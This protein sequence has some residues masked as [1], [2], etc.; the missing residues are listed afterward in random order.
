MERPIERTIE[1]PIERTIERPIER[2][3]ERLI[4]RPIEVKQEIPL[5]TN[6]PLSM[7]AMP[8]HSAINSTLLQTNFT[9][10]LQIATDSPLL[11]LSQVGTPMGA[12]LGLGGLGPGL[13]LGQHA[14]CPS[15]AVSGFSDALPNAEKIHR[16]LL[17]QNIMK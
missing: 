11:G 1:R 9:T 3:M 2:P 7:P 17:K 6:L 8:A 4:E 16:M 12:E 15:P 13:Q 14:L 5:A 10:P